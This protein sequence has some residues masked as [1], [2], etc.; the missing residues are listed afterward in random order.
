MGDAQGGAPDH[1]RFEG[2]LNG[3]LRLGIEGAGRLIENEDGRVAQDRPGNGNA[4][5]LS[6]RQR[7]T[8]FSD[9]RIV[10]QR[11]FADEAIGMSGP[12][13]SLDLGVG[14]PRTPHADVGPDRVV[15]EHRI[16]THHRHLVVEV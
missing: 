15:E 9:H 12:G 4:L 11:L 10:A 2:G 3:P 5:T 7:I 6:A 13:R 8:P 1:E 16:L 14:G